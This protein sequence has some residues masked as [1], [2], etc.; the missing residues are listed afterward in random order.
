M[1][2]S[3]VH[4]LKSVTVIFF[5][6]DISLDLVFADPS[7]VE[8]HL[9]QG[10]KFLQAG[11]L[12]DA[13]LHYTAAVEGDPSNYLTYFKRAAV[14]LAIGQSKKALPDLDMTVQLKPDFYKARLQKG[15]T[16]LKLGKVPEAEADFNTLISEGPLKA[17]AEAQLSLIPVLKNAVSSARSF[18]VNNDFH[19]AIELLGEA[20]EIS[21]W[22]VGLREMRAEC[23]EAVGM[24]QSAISDI[25]MTS[26]LV[27]DNTEAFMRMSLLYYFLG[28]ES[29]SLREIR[30]C[31][32]LDPD[33]KECFPHYKKVKKL[34]KQLRSAEEHMDN[35]RYAEAAEKLLSSLSTEGEIPQFLLRIREKLC[36]CYYRLDNYSAGMEW[37]GLALELDP[38]NMDVLCDRAEL[39]ISHQEYEEAIKDYQ[40]A[41]GVENHP[42]KVDEG[43]QKAQRL[44]K[45]S[46]KRD[47]Y[48]ILGV[49]R[50]A[51]KSEVTK[52]YRKLARKWHPDAYDGEDREK[53]EKMFLDIAAAK[54]VLTDPDLRQRFDNG[55]DPLDAEQNSGGFHHGGP[56][57]FPFG[58]QGF[59]FKFRYT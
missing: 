11:Q 25:K 13:L 32:R 4:W 6:L 15:N 37:C 5:S 9:E 8:S 40:T 38:E 39:F 53:A 33:H 58:G 54:E 27:N 21:P 36:H 44:L 56:F 18:M 52:A 22:D 59:T 2:G 24:Y 19:P 26:R 14:Y 20:I 16:L 45:Q 3:V 35:G 48:K 28:E 31:L 30:E 49:S 51:S 17:E 41:N 12:Q 29:D 43:L 23:Y 34:D 1:K 7:D 47:Y 46:Q 50:T 10:K 55:E 57:G 42:R